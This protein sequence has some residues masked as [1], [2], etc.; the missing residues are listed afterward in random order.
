M[1]TPDMTL[2]SIPADPSAPEPEA[3]VEK[4]PRR[5]R[6]KLALMLLLLGLVAMFITIATWYLLFRKPLSELPIP[7]VASDQMPGFQFAAYDLTKPLGIAVSADGAR[8]YVTQTEGTEEALILDAQGT[9]IGTL[10]PPA[11]VAPK[12]TQMNVAVDPTSGDV[13]TTDRMAGRVY[14][15]GADGAYKRLFD[16]GSAYADW[17][18]LGIG[19]DAKGDVYVTD[20]G[21]ATQMVHE[22]TP[23]AK[24]VRDFGAD[25]Q[26]NYPTGVAEDQAGN[27][28]LTDSSNGRLLVFDALGNHIGTISR[29][30]SPGD[31]GLPR[32]LAIDDRNRVYVVDSVAHRVQVYDAINPGERA[33]RYLDAFGSEGTVDGTFE[34]PNGIA[35]D[36]RGRVYVAD[37]NND[38]IQ[39]WSY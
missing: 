23:D 31:L 18:P 20:V 7:A 4:E 38:R 26:L 16:P 3:P 17:Q 28:Y 36:G 19:F 32:G 34:F 37:W 2:G 14:V 15:Y 35:V 24:L 5:S 1:T 27:V 6:R 21:G 33:P 29:G 9:K 12:A 39:V 30:T 22:F 25:E 11:S 13:Y 8:I 10:K